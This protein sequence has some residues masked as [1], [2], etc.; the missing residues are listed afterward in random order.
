MTWRALSISPYS[1]E[2]AVDKYGKDGVD[3]VQHCGVRTSRFKGVCWDDQ[4]GKWRAM[5]KGTWLGYHA[6]E[7]AAALACD[8]YVKDG[9]A[10][11]KKPGSSQFMGASLDKRSG[12]WKATCKRTHLGYH[13][14]EE[15]A[16]QACDSYVKDGVDPVK[17]RRNRQF[18]GVCGTA[19]RGNNA[20]VPAAAALHNM[21]AAAHTHAGIGAK[22]SRR[23]DTPTT[24]APPQRKKLRLDEA[25]TGGGGGAASGGVTGGGVAGGRVTRGG[26]ASGGMTGGGVASGGVTGG[27]VASV[28]LTGGT[29]ASGGLT[30]G[31]A[32]SGGVMGGVAASGVVTGGGAASGGMIGGRVASGGVTGGRMASTS[33]GAAAGAWAAA[34]AAAQAQH[35][36]WWKFASAESRLDLTKAKAEAALLNA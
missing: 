11:V 8:N 22:R 30:G 20:A 23:A 29:V 18:K 32:A 5:R 1:A 19:H 33:T 15:A 21:A 31:G 6:T 24:P 2:R 35:P 25:E 28:G 16:A 9:V 4:H 10:P 36:L 14:K 12:K 13:A 3:P 34:A 26:L 27:G 17:D 7:A